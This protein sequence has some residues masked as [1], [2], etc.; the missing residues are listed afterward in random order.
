MKIVISLVV[1]IVATT[2]KKT[3]GVFKCTDLEYFF[4]EFTA[5][6][7]YDRKRTKSMLHCIHDNEANHVVLKEMLVS[8]GYIPSSC[9]IL[10]VVEALNY[11]N[12]SILF[13]NRILTFLDWLYDPV[14]EKMRKVLVVKY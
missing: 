10:T 12:I 14:N 11:V 6:G 7:A 13:N 2:L 8:K 3:F 4:I 9:D 1:H 5:N